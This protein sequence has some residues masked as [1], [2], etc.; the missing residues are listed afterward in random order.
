MKP[1][2][3]PQFKVVYGRSKCILPTTV[4]Q[5]ADGSWLLERTPTCNGTHQIRVYIFEH[6]L[7]ENVPEFTVDGEL[8]EGDIVQRG[9][10]SI[11]T[12]ED[13]LKS[14]GEDVKMATQ[15]EVGKLT[16]VTHTHAGS[17]LLSTYHLQITWGHNSSKPLIEETS[18]S[19]SECS[20][21]PI[22]LAL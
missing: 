8:K 13:F 19:W 12:A 21:F 22:E 6:W 11:S 17:A 9:P 2:G 14:K 3:T 4:Q 18:F 5:K 7:V 10:D 1:V 16:K 20:G 15:Y